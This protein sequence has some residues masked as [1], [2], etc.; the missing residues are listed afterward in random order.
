MGN[1]IS[2]SVDWRLFLSQLLQ[3]FWYCPTCSLPYMHKNIAN[4]LFNCTIIITGYVLARCRLFPPIFRVALNPV[5]AR[6]SFCFNHPQPLML[7][8]HPAA[9]CLLC[10]PWSS[11]IT[12]LSPCVAYPSRPP[13][14]SR[15]LAVP[16][17]PAPPAIS[18][19]T[20]KPNNSCRDICLC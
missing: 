3:L 5:P 2:E 6:L 7:L 18:K 12:P 15:C 16:P 10:P 9:H 17:T 19:K 4:K 20:L 13:S 1:P 8:A 14:L 11:P